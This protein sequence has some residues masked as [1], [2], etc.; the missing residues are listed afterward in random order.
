M[1]TTCFTVPQLA[2]VGLSE[3]A[4][5]DSDLE[6]TVRRTELSSTGAGV[7]AGETV[8]FFKLVSER[9][10]GRILGAQCAAHNASDLIYGAAIALQS[11]LTSHDIG[12]SI[13]VHPSMA[14]AVFYSGD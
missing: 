8:G 2:T 4:A 14:E 11:G 10:S 13:A 3:Q 7:V 5:I 1:P 6:V 9:K 12:R